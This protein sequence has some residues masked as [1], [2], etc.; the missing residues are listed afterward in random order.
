MFTRCNT[1]CKFACPWF[2]T[3]LALRFS[4]SRS[5]LRIAKI[6]VFH[7]EIWH[8]QK[9]LSFNLYSGLDYPSLYLHSGYHKTIPRTDPHIRGVPPSARTF[10]LRVMCASTARSKVEKNGENTI[11][12][13]LKGSKRPVG[14]CA[15]IPKCLFFWV[16]RFFLAFISR[17]LYR[18]TKITDSNGI[19]ALIQFKYVHVLG[20]CPF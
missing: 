14:R 4:K 16:F 7:D 8:F 18:G 1:R 12:I 20:P 13:R 2:I 3:L 17:P 11:R 6:D 15:T 9:M 5:G 10:I 19:F